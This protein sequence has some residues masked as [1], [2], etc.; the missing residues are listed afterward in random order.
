MGCWISV[1]SFVK[2]EMERNCSYLKIICQYS[3]L[4]WFE[5]WSAGSTVSSVGP[6]SHPS[7]TFLMWRLR[8]VWWNVL[9]MT[10]SS[11]LFQCCGVGVAGFALHVFGLG[12]FFALCVVSPRLRL[13]RSFGACDMQSTK[14]VFVMPFLS[15]ITVLAYSYGRQ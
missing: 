12:I 1:S 13:V 9:C 3:L 8:P 15:V 7:R 14:F 2:S 10:F 5:T 6:F 11:V 4:E